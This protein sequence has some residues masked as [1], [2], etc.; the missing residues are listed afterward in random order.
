M[1]GAIIMPKQSF[2]VVLEKHADLNPVLHDIMS[3]GYEYMIAGVYI[4]EDHG[5]HELVIHHKDLADTD[6]VIVDVRSAAVST[7]NPL[8][9]NSINIPIEQLAG[10]ITTLDKSVT[11]IPYC[12]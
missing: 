8:T 5:V 2:I 9:Q 1:L 7:A 6:A 12:G 4:I 10:A 3:I 11:Y